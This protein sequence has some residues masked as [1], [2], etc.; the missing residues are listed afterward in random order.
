MSRQVK[1]KT[2]PEKDVAEKLQKLIIPYKA[3]ACKF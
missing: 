2:K 3:M 1:F